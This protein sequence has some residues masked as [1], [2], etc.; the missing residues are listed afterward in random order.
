[1]D[2]NKISKKIRLKV[3][4]FLSSVE[5]SFS[6]LN[7]YNYKVKTVSIATE[8][9]VDNIINVFY[10]NKELNR[11]ILIQY[12]PYD[13]D[14]EI[15]D[16]ISVTIYKGVGMNFQELDF[17]I[18]LE[19]YKPDLDI[20]KLSSPMKNSNYTFKEN[21]KTSIAGYAYYLKDIGLNLINGV[22]WE[23]GLV[24]DWSSAES[25]LYQQQKKFLGNE[26]NESAD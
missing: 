2:L 7:E 3:K 19:K 1:M 25:M 10:E 23:E 8:Y 26:D 20:E 13:I 5:A 22:E 17:D 16:L 11:K 18:Y 14:E 12:Q 4:M 21:I 24:L 15:V 9:V 6:Y